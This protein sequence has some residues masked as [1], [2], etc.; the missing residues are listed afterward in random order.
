MGLRSVPAHSFAP[1]RSRIHK[2]CPSGSGKTPLTVPISLPSGR[3]SQAEAGTIRVGGRGL[4]AQ[5]LAQHHRQTYQAEHKRRTN[6]MGTRHRGLLPQ[7]FRNHPGF[8]GRRDTTR[9][10]IAP[11]DVMQ[12][13]TS[14]RSPLS[15]RP[16]RGQ[17]TSA[18]TTMS[19]P[20]DLR[21]VNLDRKLMPSRK[22]SA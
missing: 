12:S 8:A 13:S 19:L 9:I 21:R 4:G 17:F 2:C 10:A 16:R 7:L 14:V 18:R 11:R 1:Q 22:A 3:F 5:P 20:E 15:L 6:S